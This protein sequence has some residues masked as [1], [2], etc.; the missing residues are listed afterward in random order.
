LQNLIIYYSNSNYNKNLAL[1]IQKKLNCDIEEIIDKYSDKEGFKLYFTGGLSTILGKKTEISN[2]KSR[3]EE[4]ENIILL[5]PIWVGSLPP[6]IK[7]FLSQN[8]D[9][10]NN[11]VYISVS[12]DGHK[13]TDKALKGIFAQLGKHTEKYLLFTKK[14]IDNKTYKEQLNK[15]IADLAN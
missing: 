10:I 13:N 9:K 15:F 6:A 5:S 11:L 1:E 4:Y 2:L 14:E 8:K 12:G 3:L 7:S